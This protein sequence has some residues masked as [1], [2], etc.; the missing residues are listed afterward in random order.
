MK[1]RALEFYYS[2]YTFPPLKT[3]KLLKEYWVLGVNIYD[4]LYIHNLIISVTSQV[5]GRKNIKEIKLATNIKN[6]HSLCSNGL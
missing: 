2:K 4:G 6:G 1:I 3:S 5:P